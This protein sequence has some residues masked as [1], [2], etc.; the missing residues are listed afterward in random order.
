MPTLRRYLPVLALSLLAGT[1]IPAQ[2]QEYRP[3]A[4]A[5]PCGAQALAIR[6]GAQGF[7]IVRVKAPVASPA[8]AASDA[9]SRIGIA[10]GATL[11]IDRALLERISERREATDAPAR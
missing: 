11:R 7:A 8:K 2:A 1:A 3:D 6:Q 9:A 10:L 4:E 5:Y